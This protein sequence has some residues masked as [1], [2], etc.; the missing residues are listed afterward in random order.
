MKK[1]LYLFLA[2]AAVA[3]MVLGGCGG[4]DKNNDAADGTEP[5]QKQEEEIVYTSEDGRPPLADDLKHLYQGAAEIYA[6]IS[7]GTF[8]ADVNT[9]MEKNGNTYYK[10]TDERFATYDDFQAYLE[11]YF[12]KDFVS[13]EILAEKNIQ[14]VKGDDG[15]LYF[16]GGGRGSN[17]F[18]A[19]HVFKLDRQTD[20]EIDLT[21]T[22]YY[23][24]GDSA[25]NGEVFYVAPENADEF[26]TTDYHF[27]MLLEDGEWKFDDFVLFY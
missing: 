9:T 25:Y 1:K 16:L 27:V 19:G 14:F 23:S 15:A 8:D 10:V 22:A 5:D 6:E 17:I 4:K 13:S 2:C 12:T 7:L 11:Q 18:Y 21:A 3:A 26:S 20:K 24:T